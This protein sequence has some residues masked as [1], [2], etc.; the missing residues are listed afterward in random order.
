MYNF[1]LTLTS[2]LD[3]VGDLR[4]A[5]APLPLGKSRFHCIGDWV[6]F[7]AGL[8]GCGEYRPHRASIPGPS[9]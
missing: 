6:C 2:A 1:T 9:S 8:D 3:G 5:P 4:H 7:R